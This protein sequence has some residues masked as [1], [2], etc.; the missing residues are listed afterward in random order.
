[1]GMQVNKGG[2]THAVSLPR[3]IHEFYCALTCSFARSESLIPQGTL[4]AAS[5]IHLVSRPYAMLR[6]SSSESVATKGPA[7]SSRRLMNDAG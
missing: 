5:G 4:S 3:I 7:Q 1:M 2:K 6:P